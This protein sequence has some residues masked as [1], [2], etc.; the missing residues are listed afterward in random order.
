MV[1][2]KAVYI[3]NSQENALKNLNANH[4]KKSFILFLFVIFSIGTLW[5][6]S[7]VETRGCITDKAGEPLVGAVVVFK[8][9]SDS[10]AT[11]P[12][13]TDGNGCFKQ[14]LSPS[15]YSYT[16]SYMG[17][18]YTPD[19]NLL[20]VKD[21]IINL[22]TISISLKDVQLDEVVVKGTR[23]F[24]SYKGANPVYNLNANPSIKGS[25]L[26]DG[27]KYLPGI[28]QS[29]DAGLSAYGIYNV[30]IALNGR[31]LLRPKEEVLSYLTT[32]STSDVE[33]V[34]VIRNP[35]PEYGKNLDV[36][37]NII[38][39][40]KS[41]QDE[42]N[43]FASSDITCQ[44]GDLFSEALRGR[45]NLNKG[46]SRNYIFSSFSNIKRKE[47]LET[48]FGI[49][50]TNITPRRLYSI[51]GGSDLQLSK[52]SLLGGRV[53]YSKITE[54]L[55][56]NHTSKIKLDRDVVTG[57]LYHHLNGHNWAWDVNGDML[58]SK[59]DILYQYLQEK[60]SSEHDNKTQSYRVT[61][62]FFYRFSP[63]FKIQTGIVSN[64]N[65]L[66]EKTQEGQLDL[67]YKEHQN[68]LYSTF[69]YHNKSLDGRMGVRVNNDIRTLSG[70]ASQDGKQ[71]WSWWNWQPYFGIDYGIAR[72]HLLSLA[73]SSYYNRPK[74]R[75]L[76]PYT[77]GSSGF[78]MR[79]G[80]PDLK[81]SFRYNISLTYSFMRAASL[82]LSYSD[83]K[84]P[85]VEMISQQ[86][87][88]HYLSRN[89]LDKSR[90]F[91][92]VAGLP[93]PIINNRDIGI[94]WFVT[95]YFAFHRQF[96]KGIVNN[97][98]INMV[99]NAYYL[100][101]SQNLNLPKSWN[102]LAQV[103]YYS[104]L[105][106][107]VYKTT[108]P[109][110][111]IDLTVSK[112]VAHWKFALSGRDLLNSNIA[113]GQVVGLPTE[114]RFKKNWHKPSVTLSIS[115]FIGN[116]KLKRTRKM[117]TSESAKRIVSTADES[118]SFDKK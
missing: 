109:Q 10:L 92:V 105:Y 42:A 35:G 85:I 33:S 88:N 75:D 83:E 38:T 68:S 28:Y 12:A 14:L 17:E 89:N 58:F 118:I 74:F 44:R 71:R 106:M 15:R 114:M 66:N 95:T 81:N 52:Y 112:R 115:L 69:Y 32:F 108:K 9:Q 5:A 26:L 31:V 21:Q 104:P 93:I 82:E 98:H 102:I 19:Y 67:R 90:Y 62:N 78:L 45:F 55:R 107:G 59:N 41:W 113:E 54:S 84:H 4:M 97:N 24:V 76:L 47:T 30:T 6:Q 87:S 18:K 70:V 73:M 25:N 94:N 37:L 60:A 72:H 2:E 27:I 99:F 49:D 39:K 53:G 111:W 40:K 63:S 43:L 8:N 50:T 3:G 34:E 116:D 110:W 1:T 96:D 80:N 48:T 103:T 101:H 7:E 79:K 22:G 77:S 64:H 61:S 36:V 20:T 23:P 100:M 13:V 29:S 86:G 16:I 11:F 91:R 117:S 56:N 46:I 65:L 51:G 57:T